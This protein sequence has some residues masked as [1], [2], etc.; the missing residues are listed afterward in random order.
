MLLTSHSKNKLIPYSKSKR[1]C[2]V[3]QTLAGLLSELEPRGAS[4]GA[5]RG[6]GAV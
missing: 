4:D 5:G 2:A 6:G 1:T 3:N